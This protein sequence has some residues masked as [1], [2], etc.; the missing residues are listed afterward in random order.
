MKV[1]ITGGAGFIGT[2]LTKKLLGEGMDIRVLDMWPSTVPG[3]ESFVGSILDR[4]AVMNAV[5]SC[6][7][8]VHLAAMIGVHRTDT[9]PLECMEVNLQGA[10]CVLDACIKGQVKKIV[11][12]SSS[13]VYGDSK[14]ASI[15][16]SHPLMPQSIYAIS[17]IAAEG[18]LR[19]YSEKYGIDYSIV[20]FF[21]VYGTNQVAEFVVPRFVKSAIDGV[22]LT[23]YGEGNQVRCFCYM[24]DAAQGVFLAMTKDEANGEVFNIGNDKEPI[25]IKLLAEKIVAISSKEL[26]IKHIELSD[27]DRD[28]TRE[29]FLRR[30]E[31]TK[32]VN[33]L[34]YKPTIFLEEGLAKVFEHGHISESRF[35]PLDYYVNNGN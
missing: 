33:V 9:Q 26:E 5:D 16:E 25:T 13:E 34:G 8:V 30:P 14:V 27:S 3:V 1:L 2:A 23:V 11:F 24:D 35:R 7:I 18:Y 19:A 28:P 4:N 15:N 31:I 32:A 10:V 20:R 17:K 6:D 12:S 22:P 29:I 21:N